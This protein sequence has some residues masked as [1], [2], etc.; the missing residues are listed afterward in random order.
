MFRYAR[1][2]L[3]YTNTY[4]IKGE[5]G[6]L[7]IDAGPPGHEAAFF[8]FLERTGIPPRDIRLAVITHVHAD[9]VGSL[10]KIRKKCN[11]DVMVHEKEAHL[12][13]EGRMKMPT[14]LTPITKS[15]VLFSKKYPKIAAKFDTYHP[16]SPNI[17]ITEETNLERYGF[18][19]SV[20]PT[21]GHSEGSISVMTRDRVVFTGDLTYN[22]LPF[23]W[24]PYLTPFADDVDDLLDGWEYLIARG[25]EVFVP[26]HGKPFG[27]DIL[28]RKLT[29]FRAKRSQAGWFK[30]PENR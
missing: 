8:Q 24:G 5:S 20:L 19:A 4:I 13:A 16:V 26:A 25:A 11:F 3:G 9:H 12:L 30:L 1:I 22:P 27:V 14:P 6:Y 15:M 18:P 21:P 23:G 28:K 10:Y 7:V 29:E 2:R 17:A